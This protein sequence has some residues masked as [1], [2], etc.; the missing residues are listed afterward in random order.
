[1][2]KKNRPTRAAQKLTA[3]NQMLHE[4]RVYVKGLP[5]KVTNRT[6]AKTKGKISLLYRELFAIRYNSRKNVMA[7]LARVP[8]VGGDR[9]VDLLPVSDASE[10]LTRTGRTTEKELKHL[11]K[12]GLR[13][14]PVRASFDDMVSVTKSGGIRFYSDRREKYYYPLD[15]FKGN[16]QPRSAENILA[17]MREAIGKDELGKRESITAAV[18]GG[19]VAASDGKANKNPKT[20]DSNY[21]LKPLQE[22]ALYIV[23]IIQ[24]Y[25]A[26][27][28]KDFDRAWVHGF[29]HYI[30]PKTTKRTIKI[31]DVKGKRF[32]APRKRH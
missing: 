32:V 11:R 23:Y 5:E 14:V 28:P 13:K 21:K 18:G 9:S 15:C 22:A 26:K 25:R 31:E 10:Y 17:Q 27:Y 8:L 2:P 3:Y 30:M 20:R 7:R 12:M 6:K 24:L 29:Y 4:E 19:E 1:M 16:G